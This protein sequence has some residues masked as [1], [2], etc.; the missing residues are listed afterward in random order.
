MKKVWGYVRNPRIIGLMDKKDFVLKVSQIYNI[1]KHDVK[2]NT[3]YTGNEE[4]LKIAPQ[5]PG[6]IVELQ[7]FA[8]FLDAKKTGVVAIDGRLT[9][10]VA[11]PNYHYRR[12]FLIES[13]KSDIDFLVQHYKLGKTIKMA[14]KKTSHFFPD[15]SKPVKVS[16][17]IRH[18]K[19]GPS[20][21]HYHSRRRPR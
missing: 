17:H 19:K 10:I 18:T 6:R 7:D 15:L 12:P 5:F 2:T 11:S 13:D 4:E 16:K 8:H 14:E 21:V 1:S 20:V 3:C 9:G